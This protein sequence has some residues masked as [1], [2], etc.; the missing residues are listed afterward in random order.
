MSVCVSMCVRECVRVSVC[1][2]V[3]M[4]AYVCINISVLNLKK[5]TKPSLYQKGIRY[6]QGS[7]I[8]NKLKN[9]SLS[10]NIVSGVKFTSSHA[11]T[12]RVRVGFNTE[13]FR[14]NRDLLRGYDNFS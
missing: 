8:F 4:R 1:G 5:T 11:A 2:C 10:S 7:G 6:Q 13:E 3:C 14:V 12:I 9:N